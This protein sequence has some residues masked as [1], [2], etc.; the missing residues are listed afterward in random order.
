MYAP[1]FALA[2]LVRGHINTLTHLRP[3][4]NLQVLVETLN[5]TTTLNNEVKHHLP[6]EL[7]TAVHIA[8]H[9]CHISSL[10]V[11]YSSEKTPNEPDIHLT[12]ISPQKAHTLCVNGA[13]P[14]FIGLD[15]HH[16]LHL[17]ILVTNTEQEST[18]QEGKDTTAYNS[19]ERSQ[20]ENGTHAI[21]LRDWAHHMDDD[22]VQSGLIMTALAQWH[23]HNRYCARCGHPT[24][25]TH[26]GWVRECNQC[27]ALEYPRQDPAVIMTL[28]DE[29]DRILLAHNAAWAPKR[30][31]VLAGFVDAGETPEQAVIREVHEEVGLTV[32]TLQSLGTQPWPY[33]RSLM[34]AYQAQVKLE[35]H[36]LQLAT[37]EIT[38]A[39]WFTREEM[40]CAARNKTIILPGQNTI[41]YGMISAWYGKDLNNAI[42]TQM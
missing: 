33:P 36:T 29:K 20:L 27:H 28:H 3:Q 10:H 11:I 18:G 7:Q 17:A 38:W 39:Q 21:L 23:A 14:I 6:E 32:H 35:T 30:V 37:D 1:N 4:L 9:S 2:P 42:A 15:T 8:I 25:P 19:D 5:R 34:L 40:I 31:S 26:S 16:T 24:K 22:D 12:R 41:A 13:I